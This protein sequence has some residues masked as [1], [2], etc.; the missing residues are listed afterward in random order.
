M[1]LSLYVATGLVQNASAESL[2]LVGDPGTGKS[3]QLRRFS[4]EPSGVIVGD[5]TVDGL[6]EAMSDDTR[7]YPLRHIIMPEFGRIFGHRDDTVRAVTGLLTSLMTRDAGKELAGPM[8]K[9]R[10]DFTGMQVG[11]LAA[12][13]T[14]VF[15]LHY[16]EL[17]STGFLSRFT[18]LG[19]KRSA[20]ERN[21][22]M[23]N[24]FRGIRTDLRP[25]RC[26]LPLRPV[27]VRGGEKFGTQLQDWVESWNPNARERLAGHIVSL[28]PAVALLSGRHQVLA[29][30]V[31][32][33][34][35]FQH[36][37]E[38]L[39]LDGT[40]KVK[41]IPPLP[42]YSEFRYSLFLNGTSRRKK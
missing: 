3:E 13:P 38:S 8:G 7:P 11:V 1:F 14:D 34:K 40:G 26:H 31:E 6:R 35:L 9:R 21:R 39:S 15:N 41:L 27:V 2:L 16:K 10:L 29:Q 4:E 22:V 19:V 33:L 5:I 28:L 32:V 20:E 18:I 36:Y 23:T 25:F 30:D 12:M 17:L 42:T 24:I 37:F